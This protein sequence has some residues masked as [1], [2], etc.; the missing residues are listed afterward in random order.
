MLF[1]PSLKPIRL[2]GVRGPASVDD[3][4]AK[5]SCDHL[6]TAD[7]WAARIM[8]RIACSTTRGSS[9]H[10]WM[11]TSPSET[12]GF[13]VSSPGI[14]PSGLNSAG[15]RPASPNRGSNKLGPNPTVMVSDCAPRSIASPVSFGGWSPSVAWRLTGCPAVSLA[16]TDAHRSSISCNSPVS[17]VVTSSAANISRCCWGVVMPACRSP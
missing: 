4:C 7:P 8:L 13:I 6:S 1:V 9:A 14:A 16:A 2:R 10:A 15:I 12:A 3:F 17:V 11:H 5:P